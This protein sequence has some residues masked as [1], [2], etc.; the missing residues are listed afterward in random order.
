M[1][2][3]S[4]RDSA[5]AL[6]LIVITLLYL[7][8]VG[9]ILY[10]GLKVLRPNEALVLTLFGK[11]YGTLKEDG[12]FFVNPFTSAINPANGGILQTSPATTSE[13]AGLKMLGMLRR[14]R[15]CGQQEEDAR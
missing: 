11:Y 10:G 15:E 4:A 12:F 8:L 3:D 9:P 13:D 14:P 6:P 7:C 1:L 2:I 5:L